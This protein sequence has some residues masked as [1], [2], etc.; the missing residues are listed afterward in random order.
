[1]LSALITAESACTLVLSVLVVL[2]L[3]FV[4]EAKEIAAIAITSVT[5]FICLFLSK[6]KYLSNIY[7]SIV[8]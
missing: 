2:E 6:I 5:F 7:S 3:E 8:I 4:Q 1:V